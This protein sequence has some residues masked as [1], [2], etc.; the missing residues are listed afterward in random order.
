MQIPVT[1]INAAGGAMT[2]LYDNTASGVIA[3]WDLS[4][5]AGTYA[6]LL[7][8]VNARGDDAGGGP[9]NL[10]LRFNADSGANYDWQLL[11]GNGATV[12]S[13]NNF[14]NLAIFSGYLPNAT[15]TANKPLVSRIEIPNYSGTVFHKETFAQNSAVTGTALSTTW[16]VQIQGVWRSTAAIN[17]ITVLPSIGNFVAGSRLTIYGLL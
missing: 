9:I 10:W 8:Y 17:Q 11:Q 16:T 12:T 6:S 7:I 13:S 5:I 15:A 14:A 4:G 1:Q 3:S 2:Q